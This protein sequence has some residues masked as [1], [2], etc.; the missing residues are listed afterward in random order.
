MK[1]EKCG[2]NEANFYYRASINGKT[3]EYNLCTDCAQELGLFQPAGVGPR[4][5]F[6]GEP[7]GF[8]DEPFGFFSEFF[9]R[10]RY[11]PGF[12][13]SFMPPMMAQPH[14][15]AQMGEAP[16]EAEAEKSE[17][18]I[19]EDAGAELRAKR[20]LNSLKQQLGEA[21]KT[22]NFEK[23]IELRDKIKE[24]EK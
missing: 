7:F 3:T 8:V 19:P 17:E 16:A 9:G 4:G 23:A 18:K 5:F 11:F 14:F 21:V 13:R 24:L 15:A 10:Q 22:E 1:C 2:N 6:G 20:E 12:G